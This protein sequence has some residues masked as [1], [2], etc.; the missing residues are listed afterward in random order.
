MNKELLKEKI[1]TVMQ[2][3]K[4]AI[5][6]HDDINIKRADGGWSVGEIGNHIIKS[7]AVNL[8]NTKKTD[9]RHDQH[10]KSI[11]ELFLNS[12]MKFPTAPML[13]PDSKEYSKDEI[14]SNLD[15]N[16]NSILRM[17]DKDDLTETCVDIE[18]PVWGCLT[19]YEWLTLFENHI[20]RHT[21][22]VSDFNSVI[23]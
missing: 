7:T 8:G 4:S 19:K 23:A 21:K 1:K 13:E 12:Q 16:L 5:S 15:K 10:A 17:I 6:A 2:D 18:L 22:Q 14:F 9:R 11:K 20:I 3:F